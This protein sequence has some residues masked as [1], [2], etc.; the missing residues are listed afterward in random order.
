MKWI[1]PAIVGA[2]IFFCVPNAVGAQGRAPNVPNV[3]GAVVDPS[4]PCAQ[5]LNAWKSA[6]LDELASNRDRV[7]RFRTR[8]QSASPSQDCAAEVA[9]LDAAQANYIVAANAFLGARLDASEGRCDRSVTAQ[10]IAC[11]HRLNRALK[12]K[13]PG[14]DRGRHLSANIVGH[15]NTLCTDF[16]T[17]TAGLDCTNTCGKQTCDVI[18]ITCPARGSPDRVLGCVE[19]TVRNPTECR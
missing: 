14:G 2:S 16:N 19:A 9:S 13:V 12:L 11:G 3:S 15:A 5:Q 10:C 18:T 7:R 4:W 8:C 1:F 17:C 6:L